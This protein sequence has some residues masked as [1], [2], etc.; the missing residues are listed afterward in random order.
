MIF[1]NSQEVS[2]TVHVHGMVIFGTIGNIWILC[3]F[4]SCWLWRVSYIL[5]RMI[6][7]VEMKAPWRCY[8]NETFSVDQHTISRSIKIFVIISR[9]SNHTCTYT[10]ASTVA[11]DSSSNYSSRSWC[12]QSAAACPSDDISVNSFQRVRR[13]SSIVFAVCDVW[14]TPFRRWTFVRQLFWLWR[15]LAPNR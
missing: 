12:L 13:D 9:A 8:I 2:Q 11:V 3:L 10:A 1:S 14:V 7:C 6:L 5:H 15:F 4:S